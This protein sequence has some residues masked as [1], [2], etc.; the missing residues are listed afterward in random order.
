A[1][2]P[3]SPCTTLFR[4]DLDA[5]LLVL[6]A[7]HAVRGGRHVVVD[8]GKRLLRMADLAAGHAQTFES[9][10]A[11]HLMHEMAV[12]P[13]KAGSVFL[14]VNHVVVENLVVEGARCA[15]LRKSVDVRME[16]VRQAPVRGSGSAES[17]GQCAADTRKETCRQAL[18]VLQHE[19]LVGGVAEKLFH[20][21]SI[22]MFSRA[23]N[24]RGVAASSRAGI[25]LR[26]S[27]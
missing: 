26:A 17:A 6:D 3:R 12:D 18:A 16:K 25:R 24:D 7:V 2:Q 15:H 5:A 4:S 21:G 11:G 20:A 19:L 23:G 9:L 1:A 13:Q 22:P 10:W 27:S 14:A 8:H